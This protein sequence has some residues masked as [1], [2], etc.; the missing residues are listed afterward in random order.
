MNYHGKEI[1]QT[2]TCET[3]NSCIDLIR[4]HQQCIL[5]SPPLEIEPTTTECRNWNST[6]GSTVYITHER[7]QNNQSWWNAR[8]LNLMCLEGTCSLQRTRS[9]PGLRLPKSVL[10]IHKALTSWLVNLAVLMCDMHRL[11][12]GRVLASTFCGGW[13]DLQWWISRYTLLMRPNMVETA[14][15]C[16]VCRM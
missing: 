4:S 5:W 14:D 9:P 13:L 7:C 11:P 6:T 1:L 8:S 3:L 10:W 2:P 12:S 15:Q 16:A